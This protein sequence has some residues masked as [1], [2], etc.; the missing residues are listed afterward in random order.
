MI[1][2]YK[3]KISRFF[4]LPLF[5][6]LVVFTGISNRAVAQCPPNIDFEDG[7]FNGW[8]CYT[9]NV[10]YAGGVNVI[11]LN[12]V[13]GPVP[14]RHEM[15]SAV[16]GNGRDPF[17]LFPQNCP[18]G[19]NHSI[20]LGNASGGAQAEGVSYTFT[21]PPG[22]NQFSL[23]YHYAV[24]F[25]GP[26]HLDAQQPRLV[27]E[28]NNLT[29]GTTLPCSS[30]IFFYRASNPFPGFFLSQN[31]NTGTPVWCKNWAAN[32]INLDGNAGKTFQIFFKTADCTFSAHFGY[33]YLDVN[34]EC[35]SSF[36]GATFCPDDTAV[37]VTAPSG[38]QGYTWYNGLHTQVIGNTQTLTLNPPPLSGDSVLVDLT[39]YNGYGCLATLT[40][41]LWDTLTVHAYA[42]KDTT[43][44]NNATVQLGG[45]PVTGLVYSWT[46]AAGLSDSTIAN[47]VATVTNSIS[48]VLSVMH[49]GGGCL[50]KD[51]VNINMVNYDTTMLVNGPLSYCTASGQS[52]VLKIQ[53]AD[54]IQWY[55]NGI[56]I[57][58][59]NQ[60]QYTVTQT[61]DYN[62]ILFSFAGCSFNT[63]I[64]HIDIFQSPVAGFT[65]N[66]LNQCFTGNQF[67]FT[68]TSTTT[69]G[70]LLYN[71]DLGDGSTATTTDVTHSYTQPG[72]YI[73][74]MKVSGDG[75]CSDS[76]TVTVQVFPSPI[77]GFTVNNVNQC[78]KNNRFTFTNTSTITAGNLIYNWDLGDGTLLTTKDVMHSYLLPGT[79]TVNL[80]VSNNVG[81]CTDSKS[82]VVNVNASPVAGF[83]VNN[84]NQCFPGHQFIFTNNSSISSGT[85]QYTWDL[86]DGTTQSA[87][88]ISYSYAKPG[89]YT[90]KLLVTSTSGCLDSSSTSVNVYPMPTANFTAQPACI[91]LPVPLRNNTINNTGSPINYLWDFGNGQSSNL[92]SPSYGYPSPGTYT[93]K[94]S[95]STAQCPLPLSTMQQDVVIDLPQPGISYP[96]KD[97]VINFPEQ[98]QARPIGNNIV[99][100][101]GTNLDNRN[102]Y[103]PIFR[104]LNPQLY[105]IQLRTATGCL[106]VD[107]QL[108]KTHKKIAI[109]VP[110]AFTPGDNGLN[111][112]LRP[113][114]MGFDKVNYFR[115]YNR[116]GG[117]MFEMKSDRPGW[118][119][120]INGM[121]QEMQT[122]V[123]MIEAVDVDGVTHHQQ[124]TTVLMR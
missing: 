84:L 105:L 32:T 37:N 117:L 7:T 47:P 92:H 9:G 69:A 52:V 116:W 104:G 71:W 66:A 90:V 101:P 30:F 64:Q 44:C 53:S 14:G 13:P 124:G 81:N 12:A 3:N 61:G 97:A 103:T 36:T 45:P 108:V 68:N 19:S 85:M 86:G 50:T 23:I 62:A 25:Q 102:S 18:N 11:T 58:G 38:Y 51:T 73:V 24:V 42:G 89:T 33:A 79:Y 95:V 41:H 123:W 93:I 121:P 43:I 10:A 70:T 109:Y 29:D 55:R 63:R 22:Q 113:L 4:P 27:I 111:N 2:F 118:D 21:I 40:A 80:L 35:S 20:K 98:L 31:N 100:F 65:S 94:L 5:F 112:Y 119:G 60:T 57:P 74:K 96:V 16:P 54:S 56:A 39:P 107:S 114:L 17:G 72:T 59:A 110:T 6:A 91:N 83:S 75:G 49:D 115:I 77:A 82:F 67:I 34:T 88:D 122:V 26:T 48:Y 46:P 28:V 1:P 99:W 78:F 76:S 87:K 15:L 106:T 8:T 120:K